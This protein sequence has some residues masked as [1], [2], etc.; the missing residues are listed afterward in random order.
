M[1]SEFLS[2]SDLDAGYGDSRILFDVDLE[3]EEGETIAV[4]GP[5]G[6]GKTTLFRALSG[7]LQPTDGDI[8][9]Q[10]E[11]IVDEA[12][13]EIARRGICHVPQE[14][15]V[16]TEMS[17]MDNLR[18]GSYTSR[19]RKARAERLEM[20]F[21]LFPRLDE[22]REQLAGTLSGGEQQM[23]AIARGLMT[24][25][26]L[27]LLDEPSIGLAP[28]LV[29][30]VFDRIERIASETDITPFFVE[31]RVVESLEIASRAYVL[32]EGRITMEGDAQELREDQ[33]IQDSYLGVI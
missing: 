30:E 32:E 11:S 3:V 7:T 16:F 5:N 17:V 26:T 13:H 6:A 31:Q 28:Y 12:P 29:D 33:T 22:R 2:V 1:T 27:L 19:A 25:P 8:I 9:Y 18:V 4:I 20:V 21:D 10:G 24:D 15:N 23:L 14:D